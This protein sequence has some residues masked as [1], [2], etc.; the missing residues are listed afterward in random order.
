MGRRRLH[1]SR[2]PRRRRHSPGPSLRAHHQRP[3]AHRLG[4]AEPTCAVPRCDNPRLEYHHLDRHA[5]MGPTSWWNLGRPCTHCH[6][7]ATHDGYRLAGTPGHRLWINPHG[8]VER[9]DD[10]T[11]VGH[12]PP[13]APDVASSGPAKEPTRR[14]RRHR[15]W[16]PT[17]P[18]STSTTSTPST[19]STNSSSSNPPE[20]PDRP[21][22]TG[23][24]VV[25]SIPPCDRPAAGES[26]RPPSPPRPGDATRRH[27][28]RPSP[29]SD[30]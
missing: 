26:R 20:P 2:H 28:A 24:G 7:L 3:T 6:H 16:K 18:A 14:E 12:P 11:L 5:D 29:L 19:P 17:T 9:A 27:R 21:A 23:Q 10:P 13:T 15:T 22:S 8:I 4:P 1:Q 30:R 25:R